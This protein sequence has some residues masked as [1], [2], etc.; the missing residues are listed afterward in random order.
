MKICIPIEADQGLES[1]ICAHFGSA[2]AFL[3]LD[4][5]SEAC[6]ALPN[7]NQHHSHGMCMPLAALQGQAIDALVVRGIGRGALSKVQQ[8]KM[9][10]Y[11][12][13]HATVGETLAAF[14]A[15][16][17]VAMQPGM[18]CQGHQH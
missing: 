12:G 17:L 18:A 14:R 8:A 13:T 5:D 16:T 6:R 4:T 10:V 3:I 9:S 7:D 1:P 11:L 15:G 2:P